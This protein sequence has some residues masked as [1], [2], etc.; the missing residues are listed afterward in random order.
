MV[1]VTVHNNMQTLAFQMVQTIS[2][3]TQLG[4]YRDSGEG[5]AG[6]GKYLQG[7]ASLLFEDVTRRDTPSPCGYSPGPR[8]PR[9]KG[10]SRIPTLSLPDLF[11]QS[12]VDLA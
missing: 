4:E 12:I 5:V 10:N 8:R 1:T 6:F 7:D 2:P 11:R 3:S 9:E